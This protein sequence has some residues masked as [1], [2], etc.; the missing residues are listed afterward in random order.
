MELNQ[1]IFTARDKA[2]MTQQQLADAVGKTRGA[3]AQWEKGDVVPRRAT[4]EAIA[5]ATKVNIA[6]L[7]RGGEGSPWS[8]HGPAEPMAITGL[9]VV[10]EVSAGV[11]REAST[12]YER[13][14]EPVAPSPEYPAHG[15][16][17][18]KVVGD[19][20][21]RVADSGEY[22]H[23]VEIFS[24]GF[25][26]EH[27][28]LVIVQRQEHGRSEYTAKQLIWKDGR[29]VLR[30]LSDN[31]DWQ[32]DI[33]LDGNDDTEI[34]VTDLVIAKWSPIPRRSLVPKDR[35]PFK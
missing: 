8:E 4:L 32:E 33:E 35:N 29:W 13:R 26:P 25:K 11:W 31:P 22:L 12:R 28:D 24:G 17:L 20:I 16:R 14:Y 30:P 9:E 6:W 5:K 23:C 18:Y 10:G 34:K 21:N 2:K 15:Q 7:E 27:G 1:R 3:V 19:S